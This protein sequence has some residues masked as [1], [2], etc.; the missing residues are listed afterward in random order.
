MSRLHALLPVILSTAA[1]VSAGRQP[2]SLRAGAA[3]AD[4]TPDAPL[5]LEGYEEP[6]TRVSTGVHDH[7]YA[8]AIAFASGTKRLVVISCDVGSFALGPYFVRLIGDRWGLQSD[9]ILLCATHTHSGPQLSLNADYPHPGN[10][11]YTKA[12]EATLVDLSGRALRALAP[13]QM[14]VGR[15]RADVGASR[16][17][18]G[19]DGRVEM[20]PNP[21]GIADPEVLALRLSRPGREPFGLL[22]LYASHSRS[23][24][25]ANT[26]VS[27]DIFG[28][29]RS[30]RPSS[31]P[32]ATA[33][34]VTCRRRA[35]T[36]RAA[37]RCRG[38]GLARLPRMSW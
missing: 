4:I 24:R 8:R 20:A 32:T 12:L 26:L 18:P 29:A 14:A 33:G 13:A 16:R 23:L 38:P 17:K 15:A 11:R 19:A 31:S 30:P 1:L 36:Q 37:T 22:F 25:R 3:R 10:F 21:D 5:A 6:E 34:R 2:A 28:I 9:E 35:S 27:G 7:L